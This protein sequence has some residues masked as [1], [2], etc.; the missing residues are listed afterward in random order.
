[1]TPDLLQQLK[2]K[3]ISLL[4]FAFIIVGILTILGYLFTK[5]TAPATNIPARIYFADNISIAHEALI[6]RF[7]ETYRGEIEVI[8]VNLPFSKFSTN[9]RKELL[10]RSL[11][12]KSDLIDVFA[13]DLIWVPRFAKWCEPLDIHIGIQGQQDKV[14]KLTK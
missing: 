10:A 14:Y 4:S 8:P 9:E 13:V 1:M 7:N 11:R 2:S 6:K 12:S 3:K 5:K